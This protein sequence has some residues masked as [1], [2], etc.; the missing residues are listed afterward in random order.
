MIGRLFVFVVTIISPV[1]EREH[2][3]VTFSREELVSNGGLELL[4][5]GKAADGGGFGER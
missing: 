2:I 5:A 4:E 1:R 3:P